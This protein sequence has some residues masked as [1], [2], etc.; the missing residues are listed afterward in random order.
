MS[1][2]TEKDKHYIYLA[3]TIIKYSITIV[4]LLIASKPFNTLR[5][6]W[7]LIIGLIELL[8]V[9]VLSNII[10]KIQIFGWL[11]NS[12]LILLFN[13]QIFF[14]IFSH[15]YLILLFLENID[16]LNGLSGRAVFYIL[17][18]IIVLI[19]SFLPTKKFNIPVWVS[20]SCFVCLLMMNLYCNRVTDGLYSPFLAYKR[21]YSQYN[22]EKT[23]KKKI[24]NL[25]TNIAEFYK[26][27][28][29]NYRD[30]DSTL[31]AQPN[32]ILIFTEGVSQHIVED[33]RIIMPN[34][35][36]Y[37]NI[38]LNFINYYNQ[39][40]ATYRGLSGQLYSGF[41]F[42]NYDINKLI[43]LQEI[44]KN[45]GYQT[46]FINAEPNNSLFTKFLKDMR[47]DNLINTSQ[48]DYSGYSNSLSDKEIYQL[49]YDT[50]EERK[51]DDM[52]FFCV[53]YTYGSHVSLD[54]IDEKY[55]DG[56]NPELNKFY[57]ADFQFGEF[58]ENSI[59]QIVQMI[60]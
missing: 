26:D 58:M 23:I 40:A 29:P 18:A 45:E 47:F 1:K 52:P 50:I 31:V 49:L 60:Q 54:S 12:I 17:T 19:I 10:L 55:G 9:I 6:N 38:S 30:K 43:S 35:K 44:M 5:H 7:Y 59:N 2:N 14:L 41:Q 28:I 34:V 37:E 46:I 25:E 15:S 27:S 11:A 48:Y 16:S 21:L 51:N 8:M 32:V 33:E 39:T 36:A 22:S 20:I 4:V 24:E 56:A 42:Q 13:I 53:L 57:D 3:T